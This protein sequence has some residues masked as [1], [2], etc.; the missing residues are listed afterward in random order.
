MTLGFSAQREKFFAKKNCRI[1]RM[2]C[3]SLAREEWENF[4]KLRFDLILNIE[5]CEKNWNAK[6]SGG[7][8][9]KFRKKNTEEK[10]LIM[11]AQSK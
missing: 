2:F 1:F 3:I 4:E 10:L 8:N 7:N 11:I 5:K 9:A 6:I